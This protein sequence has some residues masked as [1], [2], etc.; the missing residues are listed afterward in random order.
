MILSAVEEAS[1][2]VHRDLPSSPLNARVK[3]AVDTLVGTDTPAAAEFA[4]HIFPSTEWTVLAAYCGKGDL[5]LRSKG[6]GN[7][8]VHREHLDR[9]PVS[10]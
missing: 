7:R 9:F 4:R 6:R 5:S 2:I 8:G 10:A 1:Q 3:V